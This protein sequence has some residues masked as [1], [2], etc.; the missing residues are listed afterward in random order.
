MIFKLKWYRVESIFKKNSYLPLWVLNLIFKRR[1][2]NA[3]INEG[4]LV[5][6]KLCVIPWYCGI[7]V[8]HFIHGFNGN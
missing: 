3:E 6:T 8:F 7:N 2:S 5:C 4:N 1:V